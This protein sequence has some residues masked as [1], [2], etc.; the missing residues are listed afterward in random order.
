MIQSVKIIIGNYLIVFSFTPFSSEAVC[1]MFKQ[2]ALIGSQ[3]S[4]FKLHLISLFKPT[5]QGCTT[6]TMY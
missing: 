6:F 4:N 3:I 1:F 5:W 2:N